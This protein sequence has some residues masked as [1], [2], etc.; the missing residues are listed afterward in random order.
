[1]FAAGY[2]ITD[3]ANRQDGHVWN[4]ILLPDWV[5]KGCGGIHVSGDERSRHTF[6]TAFLAQRPNN[7]I[8]LDM[9][10]FERNG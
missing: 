9:T 7:R 1:M 8:D 3:Q 4:Q 2:N 10:V 5:G 6:Y